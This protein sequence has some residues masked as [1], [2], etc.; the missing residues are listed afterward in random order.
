VFTPI[1]VAANSAA[2][3]V[4]L[5]VISPGKTIAQSQHKPFRGGSL[6]IALGLFLLPFAGLRCARPLISWR[7]LAVLALA[8]A[9][10]AAGLAGCQ[11]STYTP[12]P[13]SMTVTAASGPLSHTT[14]LNLIVQ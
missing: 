13:F 12:Q 1:T 2:T 5:A 9:V 3:N 6:P 8:S 14:T 10:L 4:T 7:S 11:Q